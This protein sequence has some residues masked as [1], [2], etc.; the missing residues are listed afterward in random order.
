MAAAHPSTLRA[1]L[2]GRRPGRGAGGRR[3]APAGG[4]DHPSYDRPAPSAGVSPI[5]SLTRPGRAT[6]E[7]RIRAVE[8]R[9]VERNS[10]L[11]AEIADST[12][13]LTALFYGRSHIPGIICGARVRFRGPVGLREEGPV[14]IN[15]AYELLFPGPAA[16]AMGKTLRGSRPGM[17]RARRMTGRRP[18]RPGW[19]GSCRH[20]DARTWART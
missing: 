17:T 12:G 20:D 18:D 7:G 6:V 9:P 19:R 10:V 1:L 5:G 15:P 8:I 14:M 13:D 3:R 2:R 11:A 4:G 16:P